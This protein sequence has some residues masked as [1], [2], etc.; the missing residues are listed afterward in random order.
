[1]DDLKKAMKFVIDNSEAKHPVELFQELLVILYTKG[2]QDGQ[3]FA[4]VREGYDNESYID[5][6]DLI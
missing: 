2:Y 4:D 3:H 6:V 5:E 1:M